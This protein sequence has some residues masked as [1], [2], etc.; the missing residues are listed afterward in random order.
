MAGLKKYVSIFLAV[1]VIAAAFCDLAQ[2]KSAQSINLDSLLPYAG[3]L[4]GGVTDVYSFFGSMI[5]KILPP[6]ELSDGTYDISDKAPAEHFTVGFAKSLIMPKDISAK[7]YYVAGFSSNNPATGILDDLTASAVYIDDNSGKGSIILASVDC[8]GL[9][10]YDVDK[11]RK[12]LDDFSKATGCRSINIMSTHTHAGIDTMG[13][14]GKLPASGRDKDYMKIVYAGVE[15]SVRR[16]YENRVD[17]NL[18]FGKAVSDTL[19]FDARLPDVYSKDVT[20]LRFVPAGGGTEVWM[21][22]FAAHAESLLR[23]NSL[24]SADYPHYLRA[25][26]KEKTGAE[27]IFFNG[28]IG[29]LIKT[30]NR[31]QDTAIS[32]RQDGEELADIAISITSE[33]LLTPKIGFIRQNFYVPVDNPVMALCAAVGIIKHKKVASGEGK[34]GFSMETELSY[35]DIDGVKILL[36][37]GE[38]FPELVYGGYLGADIAANGDPGKNPTPLLE[39]AGTDDLIVFGLAN[40]E[41]GYIVPPNDYLL[42]STL[43]YLNSTVDKN[44]RKLYEET[45]CT[46]MGAAQAVADAFERLIE[47]VK[48]AKSELP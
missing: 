16:A 5:S 34:L 7:K 35:F 47:Q 1:C 4:I 29:G 15:S 39:I 14:W 30:V 46:G 26:I 22:N 17:G 10:K 41:I 19:Q 48:Q 9:T 24:I 18:Y 25:R 38:I 23:G 21:V 32:V 12:N 31:L 2:A 45:N 13:M 20:R 40:D 36:M 42:D 37:P 43:P 6:K 3:K 33:R 44:G 8:V 27:T 28:A 11:I